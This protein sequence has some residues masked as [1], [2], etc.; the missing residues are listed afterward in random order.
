M[1]K[2][3]KKNT[4]ASYCI[5]GSV[6]TQEE[7]ASLRLKPKV[8]RDEQGGLISLARSVLSRIGEG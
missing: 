1:T 5:L 4:L 6:S 8:G 7:L 3:L 2:S